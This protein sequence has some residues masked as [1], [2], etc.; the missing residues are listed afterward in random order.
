VKVFVMT[1]N[2]VGICHYTAQ[3]VN[4]LAKY[5]DVKLICPIDAA[6]YVEQP[7]K[8]I[9][10]DYPTHRYYPTFYYRLLQIAALI[11]RQ[12]PDILHLQD[13]H[14]VLNGMLPFIGSTKV[15]QTLHD[16]Q[17]H[18]GEELWYY[19]F[20]CNYA[21]H[22]ASKV[23]VH[24]EH[25]KQEFI[26]C[27]P[28]A[29]HKVNVVPHGVGT[30][31]LKYIKQDVEEGRNI[32]CLG[33]IVR[34]KGI[35]VFIKAAMKA[36]ELLSQHS[37][38]VAGSGDISEYIPLLKGCGPYMKVDNRQLSD[39]EVA[40]YL[41][42]SEQVVLPYLEASQ[43]GILS[44]AYAFGK[45]VIVTRVGSL[46]EVVDDGV[47]GIIIPPGD[48][49]ALVDAM[50]KLAR[51]AKLREQMK[52]AIARKIEKELSWDVV[53]RRTLEVYEQALHD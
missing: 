24:G 4:A 49:D 6:H 15:V 9:E 1:I 50:V 14:P 18:I 31:F 46:H 35:E 5:C 11:R 20:A 29:K 28:Q 41:Q 45:P 23:I 17:P 22:R 39:E 3:L 48:V 52:A 40:E 51:D 42:T 2:R 8:V 12:K 21:V 32:L 27:H 33:R 36:H 7:G 13:V 47:T 37:F 38:I 30:L 26:K 25:L 34:Y 43:S 44:T 53:A 10:V 16:V 19:R